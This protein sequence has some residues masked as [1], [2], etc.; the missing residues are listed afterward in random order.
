MC[1]FKTSRCV[2]Q[3]ENTFLL[4]YPKISRGHSPPASQLKQN[5]SLW[6]KVGDSVEQ[7]LLINSPD[8]LFQVGASPKAEVVGWYHFSKVGQFTLL[9]CAVPGTDAIAQ[10]GRMS[11]FCFLLSFTMGAEDSLVIL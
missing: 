11:V 3:Y 5:V 2:W 9:G 8:Q 6:I 10:W 7:F 1:I 4:T